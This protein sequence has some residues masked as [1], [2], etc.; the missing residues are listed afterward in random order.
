MKL[1]TTLLAAAATMLVAPAAHAYEG[2]Y[3]A[4]GAGLNYMGEQDVTNDQPGGG[5]LYSF[6]SSADY[7]K[8]IGVYAALGKAWGNNWRTELEFSYRDNSIDS[9]NPNGAGFSG[10]PDGTISGSTTTKALMVN[11]LYDFA[12]SSTAT[13]YVGFGGGIAN[14]DHDI[15]GTNPAGVPAP[16]TIAYGT[17]SWEPAYQGIAGLAFNLA[18]GLA[19]DVSYR[20]F[21]TGKGEY[22]GTLGGIPSEIETSNKSHSL[23]AG[24]RWNFG[25]APAPAVEYKDCWDGSSVPVSAS[26]PPQ[27]VDTTAADLDPINFTVY[28]DYDKSNL[29]PQASTLIQEAAARALENDIETVVVAGNTDTS[30]SS[31]YNQALSERRAR[32]VRDGLIA[33]GVAAD[34]IRLE[35]FGETNLAKPTPDG[36]REPLNRRA[37]VVI[38]FE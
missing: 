37:D 15:I 18:E 25:A 6:D 11:F 9:I 12:V 27:T 23:F 30:G 16:G 22:D 14:I 5:G 24:L 38:S 20:Y 1:K 13:P 35:A 33:N 28:F 2:L 21:V 4:I 34:R 36:V 7:D 8:G 19:F 31:A 3:G 17:R 10:W 26:C 32:A 29:T